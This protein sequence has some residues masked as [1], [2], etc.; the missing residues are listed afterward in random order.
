MTHLIEQMAYV[1]QT[2]WHGLGNQLTTNQPLEVWAKQA[3]LDWQIEESP[4]R[5]VTNAGV[6]LSPE[7]FDSLTNHL[8]PDHLAD[9]VRFAPV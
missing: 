1:G 9:A 6:P 5:L 2:P 8:A 3:G 7:L 4:V